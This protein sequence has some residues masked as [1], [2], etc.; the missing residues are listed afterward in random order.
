MRVKLL[1]V[2]DEITQLNLIG[3]VI[4]RYRPEYEITTTHLP[5]QA[6]SLLADDSTYDAVLTDIRMPDMDGIELIRRVRS[7]RSEPL[8]IMILSGFDDFQYA[9]TAISYNVL[10]YLLKPINSQSL[11]NALIKLESKLAENK[12]FQRI[13]KDYQTMEKQRTTTALFKLTCDLELNVQEKESIEKLKGMRIRLVF[14][15][16]CDSETCAD[17]LAGEDYVEALSENRYLLFQLVHDG[18]QA[19]VM[20][21]PKEGC[22]VVG[23]PCG[24]EEL[25]ARWRQMEDY[26]E[27]CRRM[28]RHLIVQRPRNEQVLSA[29]TESITAQ[30]PDGIQVMRIPLAACLRNGELTFSEI[31]YAVCMAVATMRQAGITFGIYPNRWEEFRQRFE[32]ELVGC[33]TAAQICDVIQQLFSAQRME[34][35]E[36]GFVRNVEIYLKAHFADE[37][38]LEHI[39]RAFGYSSAHFSRLF[40]AA[41]GTPYTRYLSEYRLERAS[42]FLKC[43]DISVGEIAKKVG[44]SDLGYFGRQFS[45]KYHMSPIRYR[46]LEGKR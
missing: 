22:V 21:S 43:T 20:F 3:R 37:C 28:G 40:T 10:E 24:I 32:E 6:L 46:K 13:Q 12:S 30:K 36:E 8:E 19:K 39:S 31:R 42:E 15:E 9:K 17:F 25:A 11:E 14:L 2:D 16:N 34:T 18:P 41:F 35:E 23:L 38:S 4:Q 44:I 7:M 29:L 1:I 26:I 5:E 45:K 33:G 27:T